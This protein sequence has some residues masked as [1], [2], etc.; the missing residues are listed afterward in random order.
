MNST[1]SCRVIRGV[2]SVAV[3]LAAWN[4]LVAS[5]SAAAQA[6]QSSSPFP[7]LE[8]SQHA[9]TI[10]RLAVDRAERWLVTASDDKTARVWDLT[11]GGLVRILRPP[12]GDGPQGMLYAVAIST[13]GQRIVVGG[14]TGP[15]GSAS[16]ALY[17]FD[18]VSGR[19]TARSKGFANT[20]GHMAFSP[21]GARLAVVFGSGDPLRF[22][23]S[24]DLGELASDDAGDA[25]KTDSYSADFDR[26]G[27][28]VTA[29]F[30]G[31]LRLYDPRGQ[32]L[33]TRRVKG[34]QKPYIARFSPDGSR[35]AVGFYD[36]TAVTIVS[37]VDLS[38]LYQADT[39]FATNGDLS[40]VAWSLDNQRLLAG[41]RF[42]SGRG[43]KPIVSW[44]QQGR[45]TP[46]LHDV[47]PGTIFDFVALA[48]D[49]VVF[50][51]VDPAWGILNA[52][53]ALER[54]VLPAGT[55]H[56]RTESMF[57]VS[58]DGRRVEFEFKAWDGKQWANS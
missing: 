48:N 44:S 1:A 31:M 30:D 18:R 20:V 26:M 16:H 54:L 9:A 38:L 19:L 43:L 51:S 39:R 29:C 50:G 12:I 25:C 52:T 22:L 55:D 33:A 37:A 42:D 32:R 36:T 5:P 57:R 46:I 15:E 6:T 4:G 58:A 7:R 45:G 2:V 13:D 35:I 28:L 49:R 21:D 11:T 47:T 23:A 34:G 14:F 10:R 40:T 53:G 56:K 41:G 17:V 3:W 27:R 24:S 8:L